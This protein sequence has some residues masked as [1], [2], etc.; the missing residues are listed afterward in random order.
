[1]QKQTITFL[2]LAVFIGIVI[3]IIDKPSEK[4]GCSVD[5]KLSIL[6]LS[7]EEQ[8]CQ[9]GTMVTLL[10]EN[11]PNVGVDVTAGDYPLGSL[12]QAQV[13]EFKFP[14]TGDVTLTPLVNGV[15]CKPLVRENIRKC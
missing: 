14:Y 3:L 7:G 8:I 11:G 2:T 10:L 4:V 13:K 6:K 15:A 9:D 1:M 12:T 5:V